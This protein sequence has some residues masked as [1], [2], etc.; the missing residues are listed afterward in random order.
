SAYPYL[1]KF[2]DPRGSQYNNENDSYILRLAEIY[3]IYAEAENEINGPTTAAYNAFNQLRIRARKADGTASDFPE[4]LVEG[5][6]REDFRMAI[7]RERGLELLGEDRKRYFDLLRMKAPT[8]EPMYLY[9]LKV[10]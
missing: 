6:S 7:F 9:Q 8:G 1:A 10:F 5:L 2:K 4:D 3:L